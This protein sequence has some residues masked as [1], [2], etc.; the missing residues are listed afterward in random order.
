LNRKLQRDKL[1]DK[2]WLKKYLVK[3]TISY[4]ISIAGLNGLACLAL[5]LGS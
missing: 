1:Q 5:P 2:K 4:S 3:I